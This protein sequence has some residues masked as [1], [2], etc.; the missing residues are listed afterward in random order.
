MKEKAF[1]LFKN[2]HFCMFWNIFAVVYITWYGA[3]P[4]WASDKLFVATASQIGLDYPWHFKMWGIFSAIAIALNITYMYRR[5]GVRS[6][7]GTVFMCIGCASIFVTISIPSTEILSL[8]LVAHWSSA[9]MFAAFNAASIGVFLIK[10]MKSS[11]KFI[12]TF[13]LFIFMLAL[14]II[15]LILFG[16]NGAIESIPYWGTYVILF[17][18]N[19]TNFYKDSLPE[20]R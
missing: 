9:L 10:M 20:K 4:N 7:L 2:K 8:Q 1:C 19:Y 6:K 11:K 18:V 12:A 16:K 17:L 13:I 3:F 5:Y 15:L 14:M